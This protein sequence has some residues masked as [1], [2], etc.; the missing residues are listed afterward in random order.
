MITQTR[1]LNQFDGVRASGSIDI[2]VMNDQSQ[3]VKVEADDNILP[4]VITK[5]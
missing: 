3:S 4:Y 5:G 2:E 1:N